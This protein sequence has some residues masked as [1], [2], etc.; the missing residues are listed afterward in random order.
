MLHTK[1]QADAAS[2]ITGGLHEECEQAD[3]ASRITGGLHG[4]RAQADATSCIT[5][6][7][8]GERERANHDPQF[9]MGVDQACDHAE[10]DNICSSN[11]SAGP[12][13]FGFHVFSLDS[14]VP[15]RKKRR[16]ETTY[17]STLY[18]TYIRSSD[19]K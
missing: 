15:Q 12:M 4:E 9:L 6:G 10:T 19:V 16:I 11:D 17:V 7:L 1:D 5:G 18:I 8:H 14:A 2:R 3:A 13:S